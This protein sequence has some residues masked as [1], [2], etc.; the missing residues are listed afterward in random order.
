MVTNDQRWIR[1]KH[2]KPAIGLW[3]APCCEQDIQ[4]ICQ[5][6]LDDINET[7]EIDGF[8]FWSYGYY[9]TEAELRAVVEGNER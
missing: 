2:D 1:V 6:A 5:L 3:G 4:Q 9:D 8:D 7:I